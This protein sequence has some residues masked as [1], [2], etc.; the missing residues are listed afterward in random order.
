MLRQEQLSMLPPVSQIPH[1]IQRKTTTYQTPGLP[2]INTKQR[3]NMDFNRHY[4]PFSS[5]P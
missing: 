2:G 1:N 5:I 3:K 4:E